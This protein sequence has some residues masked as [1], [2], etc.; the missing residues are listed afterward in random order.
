[1]IKK[2]IVV[3][4]LSLFSE[5]V[6]SQELIQTDRPDLT[7]GVFVVDKKT[8]QIETGFFTGKNLDHSNNYV[9][10]TVLLKFGIAKNLEL[11]SIIDIISVNGNYGLSPVAIGFK[12]NLLK[13]KGRR[14]EIALIGRAQ[15]K[16]LGGEKY[17]INKTLTMFIVAFQNTLSDIIVIGY[18]VGMQWNEYEKPSAVMSVSTN[19]NL[20][21]RFT[22]FTE[23]FNFTN[24]VSILNPTLDFGGMYSF[25]NRFI[26]DGAFGKN[27][28]GSNNQN[29]FFT[30]GFTTRFNF[31]GKSKN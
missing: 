9:I 19:F 2:A 25:K 28:K 3:I 7:E 10:P 15:I 14:P 12:A 22:L 30:L 20:S 24:E 5:K 27:L 4:L 6:I 29:Y 1:M 21:N 11:Q 13:E 23:L 17:K 8:L 18:N 26:F 31:Q 16:N